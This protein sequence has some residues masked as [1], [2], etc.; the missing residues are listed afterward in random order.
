M[1]RNRDQEKNKK[2][3]MSDFELDT[4]RL[5]PLMYPLSS[6][7]GELHASRLAQVINPRQPSF[8]EFL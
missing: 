7:C 4:T 1:D 3:S 5:D 8:Q 2:I 6:S